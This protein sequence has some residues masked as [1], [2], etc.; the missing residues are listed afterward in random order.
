MLASLDLGDIEGSLREIIDTSERTD[1]WRSPF[2][3]CPELIRYCEKRYI[4]KSSND[5]IYLMKRI[6]MNGAHLEMW[7]YFLYLQHFSQTKNIYPFR[8]ANP[9]ESFSN[10][11]EPGVRLSGMQYGETLVCLDIT[12]QNGKYILT[13]DN[14]SFMDKLEG[15]IEFQAN[16]L[17][18]P[19]TRIPKADFTAYFPLFLKR[20]GEF[21]TN[22]QED[23]ETDEK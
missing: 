3:D 4:R 21:A 8:F 2:I 6:Q 10:Y 12:Y 17:E 1:D 16:S 18:Y 19:E 7:T 5:S 11:E 9:K 13:L 14:P 23:T 20:M 22:S 15:F